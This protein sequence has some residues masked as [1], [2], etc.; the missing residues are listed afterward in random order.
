MIGRIFEPAFNSV[1]INGKWY[2]KGNGAVLLVIRFF[3]FS[4]DHK[5][6]LTT[7]INNSYICPI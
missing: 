1:F 4:S 6:D 5:N 2:Y 3:N 7:T